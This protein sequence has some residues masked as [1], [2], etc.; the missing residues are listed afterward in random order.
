MDMKYLRILL[1]LALVLGT[2][3]ALG[4]DA[5]P[6]DAMEATMRLMGKAEAELPDAVTKE[7][8]LPD[9]LLTRN[10]DS[11][12]IKNENEDGAKGHETA[13]AN[14]ERR[15]DGLD[16][17]A[18]AREKGAEMSEKAKEDRENYGRSEDHPEPPDVPGP[19]DGT[20]NGPPG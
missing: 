15:E 7:I 8:K 3:Q 12:A 11:P 19:P 16:K 17:T 1:A 9:S 10:P 6:D 2:G 14:R 13:N 4:Q 5:D 18:E 20:T